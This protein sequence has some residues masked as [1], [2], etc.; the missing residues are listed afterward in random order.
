MQTF[1][2]RLMCEHPEY[3][4][5]KYAGGCM[6]C[7]HQYR[8]EKMKESI[9]NCEINGGKGCGY[10][11]NRMIPEIPEEESVKMKFKAGD[12]V[13]VRDW[14]DMKEEFGTTK[15]GDINLSTVFTKSMS[16]LCGNIVTIRG[17]YRGFYLI[18]NNNCEW[19]DEM[20]YP[21]N[22]TINDLKDGDM[23]KVKK[24]N[25]YMWLNGKARSLTGGIGDVNEDLT[26]NSDHDFDIVEI[27]DSK[28]CKESIANLFKHYNDFPIIWKRRKV[29]K[30]VSMK[31]IDKLLRKEYPDVDEFILDV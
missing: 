31:E 25:K 6:L 11:W 22:F 30:N 13:R 20:F 9:K 26:N 23:L 21:A 12:K 10:C 7:P 17:V 28:N 2:E 14:D 15:N 24:G 29:K 4:D 5:E 27:R 16:K 19:T 18:N 8:Y 3:V 1:K